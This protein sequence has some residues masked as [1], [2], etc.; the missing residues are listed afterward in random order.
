MVWG[1]AFLFAR[2]H[3]ATGTQTRSCSW[4]RFLKIVS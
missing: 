4:D 3:H 1:I 2:E